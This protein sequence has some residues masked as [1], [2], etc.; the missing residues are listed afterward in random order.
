MNQDRNLAKDNCRRENITREQNSCE[1]LGNSKPVSNS[2][3]LKRLDQKTTNTSFTTGVPKLHPLL[4]GS[5]TSRQQTSIAQQEVS[6][7][8]FFC[9]YSCSPSLAYSLSSTCC[10]T[11]PVRSATAFDS[12]RSRNAS[13]NCACEEFQVAC[14]SSNA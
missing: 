3:K 13:V 6:Q 4:Q 8:S 9:I 5:P 12:H 2:T 1:P 11:P 10:Q 7:Q 14:S